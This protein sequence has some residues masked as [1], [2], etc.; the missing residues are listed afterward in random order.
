[1]TDVT[2]LVGDY[3]GGVKN[4]DSDLVI[5]THKTPNATIVEHAYAFI[6]RSCVPIV[7]RV[8]RV[9]WEVFIYLT[10]GCISC[11]GMLYFADLSF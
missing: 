1:M 2:F 11:T 7:Q 5:D 6:C 10:G 9:M 8:V 3:R 4:G